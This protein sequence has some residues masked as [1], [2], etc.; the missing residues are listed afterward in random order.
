MIDAAPGE[1]LATGAAPAGAPPDDEADRSLPDDLTMGDLAVRLASSPEDIEAA[2]ALRWQIFYQ[3]GDATPSAEM[4]R[5]GRDFD[6]FDDVC[7][8]LLVVDRSLGDGPKSVVGTYRL[9]R[10]PAAAKRGGFYSRAEYDIDRV[11]AWPGKVL[12]LGRSCVSAPYRGRPL[13]Q[14]LWR[15]IAAYVFK[16][17]IE[18]MFGCASMP[19]VNPD[20]LALPLSYLHHNHLAPEALRVRALP[21]LYVEMNRLPADQIDLREALAVLPPLIKGYMRLGG[22]VGE[23]AVIDHQFGT[24]DVFVIVKTDQVTEKYSKNYSRTARGAKASG[25]PA[26]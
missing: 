4:S 12:E 23:G 14:L 9:I 7:D 8:H 25:E 24:T 2:Q 11:V 17:D 19:G 10:R 26:A 6:A 22:W 16:H 20:A 21:E 15:G 18:L 13:M 5:L 3:E 1:P